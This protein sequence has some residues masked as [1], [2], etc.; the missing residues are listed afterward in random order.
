[1]CSCPQWCSDI[2]PLHQHCL[3]NHNFGLKCRVSLQQLVGHVCA[4]QLRQPLHEKGAPRELCS[5]E[6]AA[7]LVQLV[8]WNWHVV[9]AGSKDTGMCS[10]ASEYSKSHHWLYC[11]A[12]K[13]KKALALDLLLDLLENNLSPPHMLVWSLEKCQSHS[14]STGE[15]DLGAGTTAQTFTIPDVYTIDIYL[16]SISTITAI[17]HAGNNT[18]LSHK[19]FCC[20]LKN[21]SRLFWNVQLDYLQYTNQ[22]VSLSSL[23]WNLFF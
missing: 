23:M 18:L 7:H 20:T 17:T 14:C 3:G 5:L 21:C 12:D 11:P 8:E 1:M 15:R 2:P 16:Q 10:P 22:R 4:A 9:W 6:A 19:A 13:R